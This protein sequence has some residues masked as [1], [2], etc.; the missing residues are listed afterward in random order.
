MKALILNSGIGKRMGSLT[1]SSP[2]CMVSL[3]TGDTILSRQIRL[4][5]EAGVEKILITTGPFEEMVKNHAQ[6]SAKNIKLEFVNNPVYQSTNYIYSIY[7]ARELL[8]EDILLLHGDLVFEP[9]VLDM[10]INARESSMTVSSTQALPEKDFK[11]VMKDGQVQLVG[12]NFFENALYAQAM[13]KLFEKD[14]FLWLD[15]ISKFVEEGKTNVYAEEAL[16]SL[17]GKCNIRGLDIKD[18]FCAEIDSIEDLKNIN[19]YLSR[20]EME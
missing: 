3:A 17:N 12:V 11:A 1:K 4:L 19:N 5:E 16:N 20:K 7:L 13:Y 18:L 14:W 8:H 10:L 15:E 9:E 6:E 2:K